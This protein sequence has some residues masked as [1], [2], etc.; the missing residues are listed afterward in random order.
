MYVSLLGLYLIESSLDCKLCTC[1]VLI[2]LPKYTRVPL[3]LHHC[4][5]CASLKFTCF[6]KVFIF[7]RTIINH[8]FLFIL[9]WQIDY[10]VFTQQQLE[11]EMDSKSFD[12]MERSLLILSETK[13]SRL[14]TM[15][16][17]KQQVYTIAK[18]HFLTLKRESKSVR[19][20]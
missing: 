15:S 18:F 4:Q 10:S 9:F 5:M 11:E 14:G 13:T 3:V 1:S 7:L 16:L 20:V 6:R 19:S 12:E 8:N 2:I 17:W